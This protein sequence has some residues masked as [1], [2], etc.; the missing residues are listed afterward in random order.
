MRLA[1]EPTAPFR[2]ALAVLALLPATKPGAAEVRT[3]AVV[4]PADGTR[5]FTCNYAECIVVGEQ[6]KWFVWFWCLYD[7]EY[8]NDTVT[9]SVANYPKGRG[10]ERPTYEP[11]RIPTT[12]NPSNPAPN[13]RSLVTIDT[14]YFESQPSTRPGVYPLHFTGKGEGA[15][16]CPVD[17]DVGVAP[18]LVRPKITQEKAENGKPKDAVWWFAD[19]EPDPLEDLGYTL[20]LELTAHGEDQKYLWKIR[21]SGDYAEFVGGGTEKETSSNKIKVK[22]NRTVKK[23]NDLPKR[24]GDFHV[25]VTVNTAESDPVDLRVKRPYDVQ[26]LPPPDDEA[27]PQNGYQTT[28]FYLV[29]DQFGKALPKRMPVREH[30]DLTTFVDDWPGGS[31]WTPA[32]EGGGI[33]KLAGAIQ[34]RVTGQSYVFNPGQIPKAKAP[35]PTSNRWKKPVHHWSGEVWIGS[36][37]PRGVRVMTLTWQRFQDHARHCDIATPPQ[38]TP[39]CPC[40]QLRQTGDCP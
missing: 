12:M 1:Q 3:G 24:K 38:A 18:I 16:N 37:E 27:R 26:P 33:S 19:A 29:R 20:K 40:G 34:D 32:N 8:Q 25:T 28:L 5:A 7:G 31:N 36:T 17:Y 11:R 9:V 13:E 35:D 2:L 10:E 4:I 22:V 30:F 6:S 23:P 39:T 21:Q 14:K 15:N